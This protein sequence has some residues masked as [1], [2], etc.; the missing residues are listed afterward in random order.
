MYTPVLTGGPTGLQILV[1]KQCK[2]NNID[3]EWKKSRLNN[4]Y[5]TTLGYTKAFR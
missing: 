2:S 5:I 4:D 3:K 1:W